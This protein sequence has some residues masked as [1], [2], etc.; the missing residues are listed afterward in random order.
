MVGVGTYQLKMHEGCSLLL[1][2]VL[3]GPGVQCN[4]FLV[5]AMLELGFSFY[6]DGPKLDFYLK[7]ALYRHAFISN[8]FFMLDLDDLSFSF[9]ANDDDVVTNSLK[10]HGRLRHIGKD[11]M[12]RLAREGLLGSL[13]NV[14]LSM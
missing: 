5:I 8:G 3:Y 1:H 9:V 4:L 6:F 7:K 13:T 11:R 2:D 14:S 12:T 10:W